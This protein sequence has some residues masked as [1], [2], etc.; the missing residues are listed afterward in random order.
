MR[1]TETAC[2][3][4]FQNYESLCPFLFPTCG[5]LKPVLD[6]VCHPSHCSSARIVHRSKRLPMRKSRSVPRIAESLCPFVCPISVPPY[7]YS[8]VRICHLEKSQ[9]NRHVQNASQDGLF[10][11]LFL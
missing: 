10:V 5:L 11:C 7:H 3:K 8:S 1:L 6:S 9:R 2:Q 4:T